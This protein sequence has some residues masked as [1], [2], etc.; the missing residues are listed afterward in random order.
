MICSCVCAKAI[1]VAAVVCGGLS[2]C[3]TLSDPAFAQALQDGTQQL[4]NSAQSQQAL[5]QCLQSN[6]GLSLIH[7]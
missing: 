3:E 1:A 7:I 5:T 2:G 4:Q 6:Q